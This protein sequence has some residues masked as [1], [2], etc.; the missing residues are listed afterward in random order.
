MSDIAE[1][2]RK[3]PLPQFVRDLLSAPPRRGEGLNLWLYKVARVMHPYRTPGEIIETL[4]A[5]TVGDPMKPGEIERAVERSAATAWKPGERPRSRAR[6]TSWP[7]VN[8]EQ[9]EAVIGSGYGLVDLWEMSPRRFEDNESRAEE[10]IDRLF[11]GDPLLCVGR[12][13]SEFATRHRETWRG[14]LAKLQLIVP[15]PMSAQ[16]GRTQ[17]G[18]VSEHTLENTGPRRF[19]VIEFDTGT[20]DDHAALLLHLAERDPLVLAVH[21][22]GKSLHG[23]FYF[24]G[25]TEERLRRFMRYAVSLGA[26]PATWTRSQ[27]V[28]M[29]D[30]LR[31]NGKRQT[32]YLFNPKVVK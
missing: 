3:L 23:W 9:R 8:T 27:F 30:G 14:K 31:D 28:R 21:S 24:T 4:A 5:A 6:L 18:R 16:F 17:D 10:I 1:A 26:D 29:P 2:N 22:G 7:K 13:N 25:K 11:P 19:L 32:I 15:S 12:R 20:V